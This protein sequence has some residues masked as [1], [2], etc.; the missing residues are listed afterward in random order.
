MGAL[1]LDWPPPEKNIYGGIRLRRPYPAPLRS[2]LR[3]N[4]PTQPLPSSVPTID[5]ITFG[6]VQWLS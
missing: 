1:I 4:S 6:S 3:A 2:G 5:R